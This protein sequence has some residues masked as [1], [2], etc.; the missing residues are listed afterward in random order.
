MAYWVKSSQVGKGML[1]ETI[2]LVL[3]QVETIL[4]NREHGMKGGKIIIQFVD[5]EAHNARPTKG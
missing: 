3:I 4:R 2:D 1:L 5:K